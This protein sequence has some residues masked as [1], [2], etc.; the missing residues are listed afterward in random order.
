M[1]CCNRS[2]GLAI[3]ALKNTHIRIFVLSTESNPVVQARCTKLDIQCFQGSSDKRATLKKLA[4]TEQFDLS[5]TLFVGNDLNDY[6]VMQ[7]CGYSACPADSHAKI[8][9]IS[10]F[11]LKKNGGQGAIRELVEHLFNVDISNQLFSKTHF[12]LKSLND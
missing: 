9:D 12:N 11:L 7:A 3:R 2:D 8:I 1:V 10:T 4:K 6:S 5:K